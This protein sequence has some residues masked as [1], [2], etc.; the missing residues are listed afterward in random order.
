MQQ[1]IET[2]KQPAHIVTRIGRQPVRITLRGRHPQDAVARIICAAI[3][4][5]WSTTPVVG[6]AA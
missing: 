3:R 2:V 5:G 6:G 4:A 1:H